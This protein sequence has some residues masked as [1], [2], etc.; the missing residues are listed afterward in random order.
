MIRSIDDEAERSKANRTSDLKLNLLCNRARLVLRPGWHMPTRRVADVVDTARDDPFE[1]IIGCNHREFHVRRYTSFFHTLFDRYR[2]SPRFRGITSSVCQCFP[3][4]AVNFPSD[5]TSC[6]IAC[7]RIQAPFHC[8]RSAIQSRS[9]CYA[10][11][12]S[13]CPYLSRC[14]ISFSATHR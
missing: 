11:Y 10:R 3:F 6:L 7:E 2:A 4:T 13:E 5:N 14:S 8:T 12:G 1:H 9:Y